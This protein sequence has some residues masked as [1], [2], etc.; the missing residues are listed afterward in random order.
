MKLQ[1]T[2]LLNKKIISWMIRNVP[3]YFF[4]TT[5]RGGI[6]DILNVIR[7]KTQN[8]ALCNVTS[9]PDLH[10]VIA[11]PQGCCSLSLLAASLHHPLSVNKEAASVGVKVP[12]LD[13]TRNREH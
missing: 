5:S 6:T 10:G 11:E 8:A 9:Y 13:Q 12:P 4:I 2:S 3:V 1:Y 7:K